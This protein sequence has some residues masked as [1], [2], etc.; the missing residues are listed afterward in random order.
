MRREQKTAIY[1]FPPVWMKKPDVKVWKNGSENLLKSFS[2][3]TVTK[4][5]S[6]YNAQ[7]TLNL[8]SAN[9][10]ITPRKMVDVIL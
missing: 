10:T 6:L 5:K 1:S 8:T 3:P 7:L 2:K 4:T 9:V